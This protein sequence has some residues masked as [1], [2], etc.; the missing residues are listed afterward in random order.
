MKWWHITIAAVA[1]LIGF[2][3]AMRVLEGETE[4]WATMF[5]I[6]LIVNGLFVMVWLSAR[7]KPP[8]SGNSS[9]TP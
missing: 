1:L 6:S 8:K 2:A 4:T 9:L 3:Y 5:W 7:E